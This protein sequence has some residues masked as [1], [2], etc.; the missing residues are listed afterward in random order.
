MS[1]WNKIRLPFAGAARSD[2]ICPYCLERLERKNLIRVCPICKKETPD[3]GRV[4]KCSTPGCGGSFTQLKCG[5]EFCGAMLPAGLL[6]YDKYLR[7]SMIGTVGAGKTSFLTAMLHE[8]RN[9]DNSPWVL[10]HMDSLTETTF[11]KNERRMFE[12]K[13]TM[14]ATTAGISPRPQLWRIRDLD[15]QTN[16]RIP[17][18]SVTIYD[19]AGEDFEKEIDPVISRYVA[20]SKVLVILIDPLV[21]NEAVSEIPKEIRDWSSSNTSRHTKDTKGTPTAMVDNLANFIR[22]CCGISVDKKID[23]DVAIV[24]TKVDIV[25]GEFHAGVTMQP[26]PHLEKRGFD[27]AD[28][29][30]VDQEIRDWLAEKRQSA[31]LKAINANFVNGRVRFFGVSNFGKPPVGPYR[32]G[33]VTPHRVLDPLIWMLYKEGIV[34]AV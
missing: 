10:S 27:L 11:Q 34:P 12:E 9:A 32:L 5:Y 21:L 15:K 26:S 7:F 33:T 18:Y 1:V 8:L 6:E 25:E 13:K 2:V 28:A 3:T 16:R 14:E 31:F 23:R 22:A 19:G 17:S 20:G 24:F 29:D 4:E 30:A